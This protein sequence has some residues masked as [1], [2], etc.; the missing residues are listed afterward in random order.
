MQARLVC[1]RLFALTVMHCL[2]RCLG[3]ETQIARKPEHPMTLN[4]TAGMAQRALLP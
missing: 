2:D 1:G 4:A 3:V